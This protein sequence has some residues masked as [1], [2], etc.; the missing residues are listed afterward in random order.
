MRGLPGR[1]GRWLL[2]CLL[3]AGCGRDWELATRIDQ[4]WY[5]RNLEEA[6]L[7]HWLV[8]APAANGFFNT[9]LDRRWQ[10]A[11]DQPGD[12]PGQAQILYVMAVGHETTGKDDYLAQLRLGADFLLRYYRDPVFGG[13]Y[14]AVGPDGSVRNGNKSLEAQAYAIFALAH[15]Y[16]RSR[17]DRYLQA[18]RATWR[19]IRD[20][21][22]EA[23]GGFRAGMNRDFSQPTPGH[24]QVPVMHLFAALLVLHEVDAATEVREGAEAVGNFVAYRLLQGMADGGAHVAELHDPGWKPLEASQGGRV[25]IGHQFEWAYLFSVAAEQG[26]N[27]VYAGIAERLL[28]YAMDKGLDRAEGGVFSFVASSG[29][30]KGYRQQAEALKALIHH[31]VVRRRDDLWGAVTQMTEFVRSEL[32]DDANGGWFVAARAECKRGAC[33][34]Q[35]PIGY[36]MVAL[37]REAMRL[38]NQTARR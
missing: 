2:L 4:E 27:P 18:A 13:W 16:Q 12:L 33:P 8:A 3:V 28:K 11:A 6:H 37:H 32:L 21:Y 15:A 34:D 9:T 36:P 7:S 38:A 14:D 1:A 5:R 19:E 31:A 24:S 30:R 35:Q 22:G 10:T 23:G 29:R 20:R 25:D 17:D 26:L